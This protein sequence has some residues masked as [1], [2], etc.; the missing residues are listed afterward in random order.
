M[1]CGFESHY[2]HHLCESSLIGKTPY[3]KEMGRNNVDEAGQRM[4]NTLRC[5][6]LEVANLKNDTG[7]EVRVLP[8]TPSAS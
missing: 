8:L 4:N 7:L 3:A 1:A 2:P 5:Q 6:S